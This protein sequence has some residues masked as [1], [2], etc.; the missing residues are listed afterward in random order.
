M[1]QNERKDRGMRMRLGIVGTSW[2]AA[3]LAEAA[4]MAGITI[5][6]VYSRTREKG[7]AFASS[8]GISKVF[9]DFA[10]FCAYEKMDGVY[11][12]SPNHL[13]GPHSEALMNCGKHVL[14]EKPMAVNQE[15]LYRMLRTA[16]ENGVL[17]L[18]AMRPAYDPAY[19][20]IKKNRSRIGKLRR[21]SLSFCQY[22]S[23]YD[24]YKKG[25]IA[26][27]FQPGLHGGALLDIGV[28]P[29][30]M[31][32]L[33][34]ERKPEAITFCS[35]AL[36]NGVDGMGTALL[37]YGESICEISYSKITNSFVPSRI[38]GEQ[39]YITIDKVSQPGEIWL[40]ENGKNKELLYETKLENNMGY[41]LEAFC[42]FARK[43]R[44]DKESLYQYNQYTIIGTEIMDRIREQDC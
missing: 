38:E 22:S 19:D 12:A 28:Y 27:V 20:V 36:D 34:M 29:I 32:A 17:L 13:H 11:V 18:E 35:I 26:N 1:V 14:C 40:F 44:T 43:G 42:N 23:R 15:E 37:G 6:A 8:Y 41:E 30:H 10:S 39:G 33:L 7:E 4:G 5:T 25:R 2:I 21:I 9:T 24:D 16:E 31:A 3:R